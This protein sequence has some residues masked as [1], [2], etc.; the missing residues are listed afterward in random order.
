[1]LST[2]MVTGSK[3]ISSHSRTRLE[4]DADVI[5]WPCLYNLLFKN[6][7]IESITNTSKRHKHI[8]KKYTS[9]YFRLYVNVSFAVVMPP[10]YKA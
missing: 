3:H 7:A 8:L 1:M 6:D 4:S 10:S 9:G 5:S 2:K